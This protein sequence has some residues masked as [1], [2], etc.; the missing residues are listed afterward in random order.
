MDEHIH[1]IACMRADERGP[2]TASRIVYCDKC[3]HPVY[4]SNST[5]YLPQAKFRC[6]QCIDWSGVDFD[7]I[8]EPTPEQWEDIGKIIKGSSQ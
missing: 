4:L 1:V 8:T 2:R 6:M 3:L 5:P 7:D